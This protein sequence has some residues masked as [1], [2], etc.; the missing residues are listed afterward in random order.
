MGIDLKTS[1]YKGGGP[2]AGQQG[3]LLCKFSDD[4][5]R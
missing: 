4:N 3:T 5:W 1:H 2:L